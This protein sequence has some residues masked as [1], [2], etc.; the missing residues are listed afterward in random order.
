M[1]PTAL[2]LYCLGFALLINRSRGFRAQTSDRRSTKGQIKDE[3][4]ACCQ[5]QG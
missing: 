1:P 5:R 2:R 3:S 4:R